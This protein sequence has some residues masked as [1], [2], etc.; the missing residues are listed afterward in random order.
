MNTALPDGTPTI[1]G[2]LEPR[3]TAV[4]VA[5]AALRLTVSVPAAPWVTWSV[6]GWRLVSD[7]PLGET[8]TVLWSVLPLREAVTVAVPGERPTTA[9]GTATAPLGTE[10]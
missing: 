5:C 8:V 1:V 7:G 6:T 9:T 10:T 3:A 2:S 4:S